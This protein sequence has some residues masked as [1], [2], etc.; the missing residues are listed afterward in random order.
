MSNYAKLAAGYKTIENM[1]GYNAE[2]VYIEDA[3]AASAF[4]SITIGSTAFVDATG[5]T[6]SGV[7]AA[8]I[9]TTYEGGDVNSTKKVVRYSA[10]RGGVAGPGAN[11]RDPDQQRYDVGTEIV[12]VDEKGEKWTWKSDSGYVHQPIHRHICVGNVSLPVIK[13]SSSAADSWFQSL[14]GLVGQTNSAVFTQSVVKKIPQGCALL[15]GA[16]GG[17][18]RNAQGNIE[19]AWEVHFAYKIITTSG[20]TDTSTLGHWNYLFRKDLATN[21]G[22]DAPTDGAGNYLY[23]QGTIQA[24][25]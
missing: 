19:W 22:W 23:T 21:G 8:D 13:T 5:S 3:K 12:V 4:P 9:Q 20:F 24:L 15:L 6:V 18:R 11:I 14:L 17:T 10:N 25:I 7:V 1:D 2:E 16:S